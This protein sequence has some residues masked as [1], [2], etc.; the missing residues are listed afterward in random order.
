VSVIL[1]N[2]K[3]LKK[4]TGKKT[5]IDKNEKIAKTIV[6]V[7][8]NGDICKKTNREMSKLNNVASDIPLRSS[9]SIA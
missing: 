1:F 8:N 3:S 7:K 6:G 9:L 4:A 5:N 2:C